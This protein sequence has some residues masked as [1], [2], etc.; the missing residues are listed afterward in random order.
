MRAPKHRGCLEGQAAPAHEGLCKEPLHWTQGLETRQCPRPGVGA[1]LFNHCPLSH[2]S[3]KTLG[4]QKPPCGPDKA[5]STNPSLENVMWNLP[6]LT[7][8]L[9]QLDAPRAAVDAGRTLHAQ[10]LYAGCFDSH[11]LYCHPAS[12]WALTTG[13]GFSCPSGP[14]CAPNSPGRN[15]GKEHYANMAG[16]ET[17]AQGES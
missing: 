10:M 16:G 6:I 15:Q 17:E 12:A 2:L 14:L 1:C 8:E 7:Y 4:A 13:P 3:T 5:P 9:G 11:R